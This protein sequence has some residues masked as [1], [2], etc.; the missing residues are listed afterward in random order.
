MFTGTFKPFS[1]VTVVTVVRCNNQDLSRDVAPEKF[2][3]KAKGVGG[4]VFGSGKLSEAVAK[5]W[6]NWGQLCGMKNPMGLV[7]L[8][9]VR[10]TVDSFKGLLKR[11]N[12]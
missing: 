8:V 7:C 5:W 9:G 11:V 2:R 3:S 4:F 1:V 12:T 6:P 10:V